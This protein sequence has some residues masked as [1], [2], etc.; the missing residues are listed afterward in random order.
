MPRIKEQNSILSESNKFELKDKKFISSVSNAQQTNVQFVRLIAKGISFTNVDFSYCAFDACYL[1]NC[2][3]DS[4]NFTGCRFIGTNLHGSSF[5]GCNFQYAIFERTDI[6]NDVLSTGCPNGENLKIRFA[7]TLRMNYQQ[8]GDAESVNK[9]IKVELA[10]T[11]EHLLKAWRSGEAY[12]R[13][14]YRSWK[15]VEQFLRWSNFKLLDLVWGNGESTWKLARAVFVIF[16]LMTLFDVFTYR[17]RS[18]VSSYWSAFLSAPQV[19]LGTSAPP[20]FP[21]SYI[22][23]VTFVRLVLFGFFMAIIVKRFNRR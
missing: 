17:D 2:R 6:D 4:C 15:R 20:H 22:A 14:K 8:L 13:R 21:S 23:S 12:Y 18:L 19:F 9:A 5:S 16:F 1:R 11:E 3:F 7:R 10:A